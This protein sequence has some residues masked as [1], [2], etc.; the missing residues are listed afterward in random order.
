MKK[1][2]KLN[3]MFLMVP[4]VLML[5]VVV[6]VTYALFTQDI[7]TEKTITVTTGD[8][9]VGIYGEDRDNIELN[10]IYTC[11]IVNKGNS[12]TGYEI[13]MEN[14]TAIPL[15]KINF[16]IS[17]DEF[18]EGTL[19]ANK[20]LVGNLDVG[21]EVTIN[22][23]LTSDVSGK[24]VGVI[25]ARTSDYKVNEPELVDG[26]L[27]VNFN[28][29]NW[30][31]ADVT[32]LNNEWYDYIEGSWANVVTIKDL[33]KRKEYAD[34]EVG[35]VVNNDDINGFF[36]WIPRYSYTLYE[37]YGM[38]MD[39]AAT[40][41]KETPGAV[42][43]KFVGK[44]V[45][46][47][48]K[49]IYKDVTPDEYYTPVAFCFGDTCRTSRSDKD[50][51]ELSGIWVSKF[52]ISGEDNDLTI[53]PNVESIRELDV[54]NFYTLIKNNLNGEVA[55]TNYG[56]V[57]NYDSH[58]IKNSEWSVVTLLSQSKYGKYGNLKYDGV[59]KE[60][61]QN[62]SDLYNTGCSYGSPSNDN[63]DYGCENGYGKEPDGIGASTTGTIYGVY[64]LSGGAAEYVMSS[65]A[66][67]ILSSNDKSAFTNESLP[68]LKYYDSYDSVD[69]A[70]ACNNGK[71][72]GENLLYTKNWYGDKLNFVT[73]KTPW[74]VRGGT[75]KDGTDAG[76]FN[77]DSYDGSA[78]KEISTRAVIVKW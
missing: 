15:N 69:V 36:V 1:D 2:V 24:F 71:C 73:E 8:K 21:E 67:S 33:E 64:D 45:I 34:A 62:K 42:D 22:L 26:M 18:N 56:F 70:T 11:N 63:T 78:S 3:L 48:G 5:V 31:K 6:G 32:N 9:Y 52:E 46:D 53:L 14:T 38:Q 28:G 51:I 43:I 40:P 16:T 74:L 30:V 66:S 61:Y 20:I 29:T 50:N 72:L 4:L 17:G 65:L 49:A 75:Y 10:D 47:D 54:S 7:D 25:K 55:N 12:E 39:G 57:E 19:N 68:T 76:I 37:N 27:A 35:T 77:V 23:Q 13:Y 44:N 59:N 41:S 58:M 60:V